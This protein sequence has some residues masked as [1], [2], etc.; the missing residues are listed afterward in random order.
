MGYKCLK[1]II[2]P[3]MFSRFGSKEQNWCPL[4]NNNDMLLI[5]VNNAS[6]IQKNICWR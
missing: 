1:I 4:K 2:F 5:S 6:K 3:L